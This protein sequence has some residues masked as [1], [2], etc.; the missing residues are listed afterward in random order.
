M[1]ELGA[2]L[3]G[4]GPSRVLMGPGLVDEQDFGW[5]VDRVSAAGSVAS[6]SELERQVRGG[7]VS[8]EH[9]AWV[10]EQVDGAVLS[11]SERG[12]VLSERLSS[13]P[14][15]V[16]RALGGAVWGLSLPAAVE[17]AAIW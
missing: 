16:V 4:W 12:R 8:H 7:G 11:E 10:D 5:V 14:V 9:V 2:V 6:V 1:S 3:S 17:E 15:E 13:G